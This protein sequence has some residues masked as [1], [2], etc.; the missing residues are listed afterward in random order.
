MLTSTQKARFDNT[1]PFEGLDKVIN[2]KRGVIKCQYDFS[3]LGGAV[4]SI[5]LNDENGD[6]PQL[7]SKAIIT[8]VYIDIITAC[9][10]T[11]NDGTIALTANST[12]DL[13]AAVD[14]DTL[15]GV[16][17]GIPVGTA[18]AMVKC[19]AARNIVLEIA[20]HALTAGKFNV[21]VEFVLSD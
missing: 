4:G 6:T 5:T 2:Q 18:A 15:S 14:A 12:G 10:S 21:F 20:T 19:T 13:L 3:T 16:V 9:V 1:S 11:S 17:A 8:Q 7:P